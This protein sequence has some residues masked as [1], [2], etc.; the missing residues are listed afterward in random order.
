V[1]TH[2]SQ[3]VPEYR[4]RFPEGERLGIGILGCGAIAQGAHLPAYANYDL[5]VV[6]VW[7]RTAATTAA[8]P[9]RFP[10]VGQVY[11][12]AEDLLRDPQVQVVDIATRPEQRLQWLAAAVSAGKHVLAQKPLTTDL[13]SLAPV[14]TDA[15]RRAVRVAVNQNGRWAPAWR[16]ATLLV[17]AGAI[18]EVVGVTHLHDK[19]CHPSPAPVST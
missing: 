12:T 2:R 11:A 15:E 5:D 17:A 1:R 16:L 9:E 13:V 18:G 6:G 3:L 7:S 8:V 10:F 19:R 14:L 4:P